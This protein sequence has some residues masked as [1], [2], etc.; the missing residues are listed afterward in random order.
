MSAG[1]HSPGHQ[2]PGRGTSCRVGPPS[3]HRR[4]CYSGRQTVGAYLR[5]W[6]EDYASTHVRAT[7]LEGYKTRAKRLIDSLG[8]IRLSE[9]RQDH[10]QAYYFAKLQNGRRDGQG[11][12]HGTLI[13]YHYL[14]REALSH[15]VKWGLVARNVTEAVDP[16]RGQRKEMQALTSVD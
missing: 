3:G 13:K 12:E 8:S 15:S 14:L 9:L 4:L 11:L 2:A 10:L 6:L 16:P 7:I 5:Q 1:R